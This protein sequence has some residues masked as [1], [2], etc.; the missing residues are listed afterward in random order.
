L[1]LKPESRTIRIETSG[2]YVTATSESL[3]C[4]YLTE[5]KTTT[6]EKQLEGLKNSDSHK[7]EALR[8]SI[9]GTSYRQ[10]IASQAY[11]Y[12][13]F[14]SKSFESLSQRLPTVATY[15]KNPIRAFPD[16][17]LPGPYLPTT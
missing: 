10:Q 17:R 6:W 5:A 4:Y 13:F 1:K 14:A 8:S 7:P 9:T 16:F 11:S 12:S 15:R 2:S 3:A